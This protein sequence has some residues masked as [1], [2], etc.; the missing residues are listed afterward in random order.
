MTPAGPSNVPMHVQ[1]AEYLTSSTETAANPSV[2]APY[3][4]WAYTLTGNL[5]KT[6]A[7]GIKTVIYIDPVMPVAGQYEYT[8]LAGVYSTARATACTGAYSTNYNGTGYVLDPTKS[9]AASYITNVVDHAISVAVAANPGYAH[10]YN[11]LF[12]DN[13]GEPYG[14]TP[15]PCD[16]NASTYGTYLDSDFAAA[17]AP[18]V[19]NALSTTSSYLPTYVARLSGSA[20]QG[21]EYEHCFDDRQWSVEEDAQIEA[22]AIV[23]STGKAP[24]PGFWCYLD[25]TSADASTVTAQRLFAYASFLLTYDPNYSVFQE[26]Y[27]SSPS[28]FKVMPET[29]FVPLEPVTTPSSIS[30]LETSSGAYV[31][32]YAYCYYR[33]S[34]IGPCE[35]AVN[36]GTATVSVPNPGNLQHSVSLSGEG[37]LDGGTVSFTS[38]AV[39]SLA[40]GT[41][42]IL[43]P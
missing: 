32:Q 30:A 3:L 11:L 22:V 7:A 13:A 33:G 28:T 40:P 25:G 43:V 4:T 41:A 14:V 29:G 37:V 36:P 5:G 18:V 39:N 34:L 12:V 17:G 21:G 31:Q 20:V 19:L 15:T 23:K 27:A 42:A 26:S 24:G 2:Y 16:F 10:P 6:Q 1:T 8:E 38:Q 9:N 35:V